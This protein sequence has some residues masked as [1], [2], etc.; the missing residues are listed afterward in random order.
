MVGAL[1]VVGSSVVDSHTSPCLCLDALPTTAMN[2]KSGGEV[3]LQRNSMAN[4]KRLV[5]PGSLELSSSFIGSG[6][7]KRLSMK[8]LPGIVNRS[9]RKR[10]NRSSVI[11][12]ELAGQYEDSFE[13]V[14]AVRNLS[15]VEFLDE[16]YMR[17]LI[18]LML[19][20]FISLT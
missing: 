12:N 14:K 5:K 1:S 3:V 11:V 18:G 15:S 9:M 20:V 2:L 7:D 17:N 4:K 10:K 13:D 19:H 6:H 16:V 8:A